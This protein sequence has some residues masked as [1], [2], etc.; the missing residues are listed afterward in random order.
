M[1]IFI[2]GHKYPHYDRGPG[3]TIA[4]NVNQGKNA[5]G[6]FVG[7]RV[8]RDQDKIDGL[9]WSYLDAETWQ[10]ILKE[11]QEFVVVVKFPDMVNGGWKTERM[12]PGNRTAKVW[13]ENEEGLPTWYKDCKVN[14]IDCGE[15]E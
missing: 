10:N 13:E 15:L 5:L 12:Y 4:T 3:L 6:E 8:G 7:Q 1:A 2:N 9:Q 14:L 11:F